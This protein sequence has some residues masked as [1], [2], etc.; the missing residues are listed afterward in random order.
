MMQRGQTMF[1]MASF[2]GRELLNMPLVEVAP[3]WGDHHGLMKVACG[4]VAEDF[5]FVHEEDA[6]V[7]RGF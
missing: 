4:E 5:G 1:L 7:F 6:D 3:E 2:M